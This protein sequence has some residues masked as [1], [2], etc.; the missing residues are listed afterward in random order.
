MPEPCP[1]VIATWVMPSG[2]V[3]KMPRWYSNRPGRL[4]I[5]SVQT[6]CNVSD[7]VLASPINWRNAGVTN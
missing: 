1:P 6:T 5:A 2:L 3:D 7:S 4:R